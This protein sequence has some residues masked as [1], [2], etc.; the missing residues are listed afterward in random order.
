MAFIKR[1]ARFFIISIFFCIL[2]TVKIVKN[3]R[4]HLTHINR[5]IEKYIKLIERNPNFSC[6]SVGTSTQNKLFDINIKF[7]CYE[8]KSIAEARELEIDCIEKLK[9][10][11]NSNKKLN[12]YLNG[13]IFTNQNAQ[14]MISFCNNN[15]SS[16]DPEESISVVMNIKEKLCYLHLF[17]DSRP[18]R[19]ILEEPYS[20]AY[21]IVTGHELAD[22]TLLD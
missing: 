1:H 18:N 16:F 13:S 4:K 9:H 3:E 11:I 19:T 2:I 15:L 22:T 17:N 5:S 20:E 12:S 14:I 21:K 6:F 7:F 8:K 10:T